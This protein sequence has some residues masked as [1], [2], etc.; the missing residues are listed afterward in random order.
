MADTSERKYGRLRK[1]MVDDQ[2]KRRGIRDRRV[3]EAMLEV[4]RHAFVPKQLAASAY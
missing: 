4:P 3:L 1:L 2:L